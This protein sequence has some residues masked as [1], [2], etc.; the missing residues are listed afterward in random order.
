MP[1][2]TRKELNNLT[3]EKPSLVSKKEHVSDE[4]KEKVSPPLSKSKKSFYLFDPDNPSNRSGYINKTI[5]LSV[6]DK[7]HSVE[8]RNGICVVRDEELKRILISRGF[9]YMYEEDN[10]E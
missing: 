10:N 3:A 7:K 9:I 6:L 8:I 4:Y 2:L 1:V 5:F